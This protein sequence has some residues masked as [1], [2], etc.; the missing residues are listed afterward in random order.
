MVKGPDKRTLGAFQQLEATIPA[1]TDIDHTRAGDTP[2]PRGDSPDP[3]ELWRAC[4][5]LIAG[6]PRVRIGRRTTSGRYEYEARNER[7]LTPVRPLQPAAVRI[8]GPDGCC[9]TLCLDLDASR[10][11][12]DAVERDERRLLAWLTSVGAAA[13][14]DRSPSGGRHVYVPL[15][16]RLDYQAARELVEAL[17]TLHPTLDAAPHRSLRSGCIRP[18]GAAHGK[19]GHQELTMPLA[20]TYELLRRGRATTDVV[21]AMRT[22]LHT[23]IGAWRLRTTEAG[24]TRVDDVDG[25]GR[26]GTGRLSRRL[27]LVAETGEYDTDRYA[28]QSEARQA[29]VT[30]AARAG[31]PFAQVVSRVE[32][33]RWPGLASFYARHRPGHRRRAL[34]DDWRKARTFLDVESSHTDEYGNSSVRR[35]HTS[36]P[37]SQRGVQPP[38][39]PLAEHAFIRT[40]VKTLRT[41]E[42]HRFK[43]RAGELEIW[44]LRAL[45]EAAHMTA[46]R[47]VAFGTRS[48][49][50]AAG[51]E[52]SSVAAVLRRLAADPD[53]WI[54]LVES[55]R[56]EHADLY[57]LRLPR[58]LAETAPDLRWDKGKVHALRPAFR[59]LG[60][61]A[62]QIF[63]A[64]EIG[65]AGTIGELVD[66]VRCSR[67]SCYDGVDVLLAY[68]L[69]ER[70]DGR[71]IAH[72]EALLRVAEQLGTLDVVRAQVSRYRAE[73]ARWHAFLERHSTN[74]SPADPDDDLDEAWWWP[75]DD[76]AGATWTLLSVAA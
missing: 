49:A 69:L 14:T 1:L 75:P 51:A 68:G 7:P 13:V 16:E 44:V 6:T 55:A 18:P 56:G 47:H 25:P 36:A 40:W 53:G 10:G 23:E 27:Q 59:E 62:A 71:L 35:S 50:V 76:A 21:D 28:S 8:Y 3:A 63:E 65:A 2:V 29:V 37:K 66:V 4:A 67:S 30:G 26:S 19:G 43:G 74:G 31:L 12:E 42:A 52:Y 15:A 57:E 9:A 34:S 45:A 54:D 58:S 60:H 72:P 22:A 41:V 33:G 20:A 5:A 61:V 39:S 11:G 32:D 73:R 24:P 48:L 64:I 70:V 38:G 46:S 17:A